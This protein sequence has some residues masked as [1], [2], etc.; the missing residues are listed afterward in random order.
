MWSACGLLA[1]PLIGTY[2]AERKSKTSDKDTEDGASSSDADDGMG[3]N[4]SGKSDDGD[5][6]DEHSTSSSSGG[7]AKSRSSG[8]ESQKSSRVSEED[9]A[10]EFMDF[11][12]EKL[13]SE[14]AST[15]A[16]TSG[17]SDSIGVGPCAPCGNGDVPAMLMFDTQ[18]N[19]ADVVCILPDLGKIFYYSHSHTFK[20][21]CAPMPCNASRCQPGPSGGRRHNVLFGT[22]RILSSRQNQPCLV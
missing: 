12:G 1:L 16:V 21:V 15:D 8:S 2:K 22:P 5:D 17:P 4:D 6:S 3:S 19:M 18:V 20:A 11:W 13:D 10:D 14:A 7:S 9:L